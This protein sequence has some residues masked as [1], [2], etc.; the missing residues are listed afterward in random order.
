M[1]DDGIEVVSKEHVRM[2]THGQR[3]RPEEDHPKLRDNE[4]YR[5]HD[6]R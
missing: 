5:T 6:S 4:E 3:G 2:I 1:V